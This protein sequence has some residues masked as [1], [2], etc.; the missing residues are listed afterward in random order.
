MAPRKT[1]HPKCA[2]RTLDEFTDAVAESFK[3][4][5]ARAGQRYD[6][7]LG[8]LPEWIPA[9]FHR[10]FEA[11]RNRLLDAG[12]TAGRVRALMAQEARRYRRAIR[13]EHDPIS[14]DGF[15]WPPAVRN[16]VLSLARLK[17]AVRLG[18]E[19]GLA[20][21]TDQD[22]ADKVMKGDR[23]GR[24]QSGNAKHPRGKLEEA[25][26]Q[27]INEIIGHL[28]LANT[29]E[30]AKE[31][32]NRFKGEL[33]DLGLNPKEHTNEWVIGY[34]CN[35]KRKSL[36]FRRFENVVSQFRTGRKKSR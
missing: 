25:D 9:N 8:S 19:K 3:E 32:W 17:T 18:K 29:G 22:H 12:Y 15:L 10:E 1:T 14:Y 35:D 27:T 24:H 28:V 33:E 2:P 36:T 16:D 30:R 4:L 7:V 23:Y 20:F 5:R 34:D 21:L 26:G 13:H 11:A 6:G 31:L